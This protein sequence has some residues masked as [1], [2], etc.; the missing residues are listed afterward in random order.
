MAILEKGKVGDEDDVRQT[1][2][3]TTF[4]FE[5]FKVTPACPHADPRGAVPCRH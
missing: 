5:G 3:S 4:D 1:V 2:T